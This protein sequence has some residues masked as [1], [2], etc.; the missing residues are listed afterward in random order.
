MRYKILTCLFLIVVT[1]VVFRQVSD[2]EFINYDDVNY[3]TE[4]PHVKTGLTRES[5]GWAFTTTYFSYWHPLTWLSHMLD[6]RLYGLNPRWHH[7]M[8]V[9]FHAANT[10]FLFL[11]LN[12]M[13][14]A[15]R[16][17]SFVAAL[18]ALH[19][20][21][22]ESVAWVAERKDV[23]SA[24]FWLL[25]LMSYTWYVERPGR[26]KYLLTLFIFV[27]GLM[28]KPMLVTLPFVLFIMDY[29]PLG[30]LSFGTSG[31]QT[32][33]GSDP[34]VR[35]LRWVRLISEKIPFIALSVASGFFT[36]YAQQKNEALSSINVLPLISRVV[37]ALLAYA[38]YI[39]K[40]I[41]PLHLAVIYPL[42][43]ALN[44]PQALIAGLIVAG[45]S[46]AAILTAK[47]H[48]YF[49][50]GWLWYLVT[51]LP[52]VGLVQVGGQ[53]MADRYTY[54]P[55]IGLFIMIAWGAETI[56]GDGRYRRAALSALAGIVLLA[57]AA[58]TWLQLGYWK[59]SI[60]LFSHANKVVANNYV[61]HNYLAYAL[62]GK[63]RLDEALYHYREALRLRPD[64]EMALFNMGFTL[65]EQGRFEE[66]AGY[67]LE[68][69]RI[70]PG[71]A[72]AYINLGNSLI[73]R[74]R[75]E[76]AVYYFSEGLRTNPDNAQMHFG[77]GLAL[78]MQGKLH[79]SI[80]YFT[81]ALRLSPDFA[82][83]HYNI[84]AAL[85][86]QGKFDESIRHFTEAL[87]LN[88][89]F[90]EARLGLEAAMKRR[91]KLSVR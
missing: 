67:Y 19:P 86:R 56:V 1:V 16:Q 57:S 91:Q 9:F 24:L 62:T 28:S 52:V 66:A 33:K 12:R 22:V 78:A 18:F 45:I 54:M 37:N 11:L 31:S 48:P 68:L 8:N 63:G 34:P 14:G 6:V 50:A 71:H 65:M 84:G 21:H 88:P 43:P 81:E 32:R 51:L 76:E 79:E 7:L 74:G 35:K 55:L 10:V 20:L 58:C 90:T 29:W 17:S 44:I 64:D 59:N 4:N 60:T 38:G 15:H 83:G 23:L 25:T 5:I 70:K 13:T 27:L 49:L 41:W 36:I 89:D 42:H 69:L 47:R 3:V 40:T 72:G 39:G 75:L 80:I 30:R 73:D 26:A 87:R 61:A 82:E 2:H 53:S 77:I 46:V 85:A